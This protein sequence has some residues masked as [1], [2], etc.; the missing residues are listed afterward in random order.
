MVLPLPP[1]SIRGGGARASEGAYTSTDHRRLVQSAGIEDSQICLSACWQ[2]SPSKNA[3]EGSTRR[4]FLAGRTCILAPKLI[5]VPI[6]RLFSIPLLGG[7]CS[8]PIQLRQGS[9][10]L[11]TAVRRPAE[12][13]IPVENHNPTDFQSRR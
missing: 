13:F 3:V 4:Q 5:S 7:I 10:Y 6:S 11:Q 9:K 1:V 12:T 8:W 2:R